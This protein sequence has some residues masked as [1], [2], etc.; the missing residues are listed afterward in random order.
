[1]C[2]RP[3]AFRHESVCSLLDA[4]MV[5]CVT[6]ILVEDEACPDGFPESRMD[7]LLGFSI[8]LRQRNDLAGVTQTSELLQGYLGDLGQPLQLPNHEIHHVVRETL[9]T[10]PFHVPLPGERTRVE[11]DQPFFRQCGE[12]LDCKK[13]IAGGLLMDQASQRF[14]KIPIATERICNQSADIVAPQRR[15]NNLRDSRTGHADRC[16][17]AQERVRG[18][19]FVVSICANQQK[20][21]YFRVRDKV[22]E[23]IKAGCVQPLQI[24]EKQRKRVLRPGE[25]AEETPEYHL[26]A[27][28]SVLRRKLW[29]R[30]LF[31]DD[32]RKLWDQ[33]DHNL[34]VRTKRLQQCLSPLADLCFAFGEDMPDQKLEGLRQRRVWDVAL[35]LIELTGSEEGA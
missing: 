33:V 30:R 24:I 10:D 32:E 7:Q 25:H 16:Q 12:K 6:A 26:E 23:Q 18:T 3:L 21:L 28:L 9:G 27:V 15:Q 22:F 5:K 35:V 31:S 19:Y 8:H 29:N 4:I 14:G 20:V 11:C 13:R 2:G 17:C 34:S 1:M